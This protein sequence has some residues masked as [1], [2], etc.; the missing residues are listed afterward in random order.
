MRHW[1]G[2]VLRAASVAE[3][4]D[5]VLIAGKEWQLFQD[6]LRPSQP[7]SAACPSRLL[8]VL[9]RPL[10]GRPPRSNQGIPA[11]CTAALAVYAEKGLLTLVKPK[12]FEDEYYEFLSSFATMM[13]HA[14][15]A[16]EL[17]P[18]EGHR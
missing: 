14:V 4:A 12:K 18:H 16:A 6:R 7:P 8:P 9:W 13:E 15:A 10:G 11:H 3:A 17:P 1:A 5:Q 2:E